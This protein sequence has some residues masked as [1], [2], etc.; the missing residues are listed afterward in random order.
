MLLYAYNSTEHQVPNL[1][2]GT[3]STL[4]FGSGRKVFCNQNNFQNTILL[5]DLESIYNVK[6][7]EKSK[8]GP[9]PFD[10]RNLIGLT[11]FGTGVIWNTH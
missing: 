10:C 5:G 9:A 7:S 8:L 4:N 11:S 3:L 1:L 6:D 2:H